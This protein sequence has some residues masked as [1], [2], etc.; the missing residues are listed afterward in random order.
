MPTTSFRAY[1]E[2]AD[3]DRNRVYPR[4]KRTTC[5]RSRDA[6][7]RAL[8]KVSRKLTDDARGHIYE[9]DR[10]T[11]EDLAWYTRAL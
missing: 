8:D 3:G 9:V 5:F 7:E 6:A 1:I 10:A 4:S 2:T 11:G